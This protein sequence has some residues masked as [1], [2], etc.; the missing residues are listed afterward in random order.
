MKEPIIRTGFTKTGFT[1]AGFACCG[2]YKICNMGKGT[3]FYDET[4]PEAKEF[5]AAYKRNSGERQSQSQNCST[6]IENT[7][8]ETDITIHSEEEQL[9]FF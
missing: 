8:K 3:C 9:S 2:H 6:P 4:D 1:K 5:C 7:E